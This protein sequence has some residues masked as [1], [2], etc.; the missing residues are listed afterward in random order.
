MGSLKAQR[1][2]TALEPQLDETAYEKLIR[3]LFVGLF[4]PNSLDISKPDVIRQIATSSNVGLDG[5]L[6]EK[7][8][9][10][11]GSEEIKAKLVANG[12]RVAEYGGFGLP[13]T[14]VHLPSRPE[15]VFGSDRIHIIGQMLGETKPAILN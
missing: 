4:S 15:M 5:S 1:F 2:L 3:A 8:I 6:V 9:E 13:T 12:K 7:A 10:A 11:S 14:V